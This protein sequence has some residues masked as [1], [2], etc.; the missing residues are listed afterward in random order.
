MMPF[1]AESI[2]LIFRGG[3]LGLWSYSSFLFFYVILNLNY[4][5]AALSGLVVYWLFDLLLSQHEQ[6]SIQK[7]TSKLLLI[8][9]G[10]FVVWGLVGRLSFSPVFANALV[11]LLFLAGYFVGPVYYEARKKEIDFLFYRYRFVLNYC[12]IGFGSIVLELI[13]ATTLNRFLNLNVMLGSVIGFI[14]G[15]LFSYI[16]NSR[17][18]FQ[19]PKK[20]SVKTFKMFALIS[21]FSYSLSII[22]LQLISS[23]MDFEYFYLRFLIAGVLFAIG[24][25]LHRRYTFTD[26]KYVG[27]A[28]YLDPKESTDDVWNKIQDYPDFIHIDLVDQT[29]NPKF[30][31][32]NIDVSKGYDIKSKWFGIK[33][34]THV[35]SK[36]PSKWISEIAGFSDVIIVHYEIEESLN[37][38]IESIKKLNKKVGLSILYST[39][40]EL[41]RPYLKEM[42][43]VQVLGIA[44]PGMSG[45]FLQKTALERLVKLNAIKK[46]YSF[47]ICFDG[48]IKRENIDSITAKYVVSASSILNAN[49]PVNA[50]FDL[51]TSS[52]YF[53]Q[54]A[55]LKDFLSKRILN[56]GENEPSIASIN[57]V[58]SFSEKDDLSGIS[59]IDIVIIADELNKEKYADIVNQ[60]NLLKEQIETD[61]SLRAKIND[62]FGPL[63]FD[64]RYD[65]V[66]HLMIYDTRGHLDHCV[67]SP[68][69][70]LDWERS[71]M[72]AK[73]PMKEIIA[74]LKP[75]PN[76]LMSSRRSL[77]SYLRDLRQGNITYR[78]YSF[79]GSEKTLQ[80]IA[81]TKRMAGKDKVEYAFH[82]MKFMILNFMKIYS[83]QNMRFSEEVIQSFFGLTDMNRKYLSLFNELHRRK[84]NKRTEISEE[85]IWQLQLFLLEFKMVFEKVFHLM[86]KSVILMRHAQTELN[87]KKVFLGQRH[88]PDIITEPIKDKIASLSSSL[89]DID[90]VYSSPMRRALETA[91]LVNK[92][93]KREMVVNYDINEIDYGDIDGQEFAYLFKNYPDIVKAWERGEDPKFPNGENYADLLERLDRF[94]QS[95]QERNDRWCGKILVVTHNVIMRAVAGRS[96]GIPQ[97]YWHKINIDHLETFELFMAGNGIIHLNLEGDQIAKIYYNIYTND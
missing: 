41:I 39:D 36:F 56:I 46:D 34:M 51:K 53:S 92:P 83:G 38:V 32:E 47:E 20:K 7:I 30:T 25:T 74:T 2:K 58:G 35:M 95:L 73:K 93:L 31:P 18:N 14:F 84:L 81:K 22:L 12:L 87:K 27:V 45:Q 40:I 69:T 67:K 52:R 6:H 86:G 94:W 70:V 37:E 49:D 33:T 82:I 29:Y 8:P 24:Y 9:A 48:G 10:L 26:I 96:L 85:E 43:V 60:F 68:F 11:V 77:D 88:D 78:Q 4:V 54:R 57:I 23:V 17:L 97:K 59:D 61:Y 64:D 80:E 62:T 19:V 44:Q 1:R 3:V 21:L 71:R 75:Q 90:I 79:N 91:R 42:D 28:L 15:V 89:S 76:Q 13:I 5:L 65:V 55:S 66:L 72:Y 50:I 16:L 63:K